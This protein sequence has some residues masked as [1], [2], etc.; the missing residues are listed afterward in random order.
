[1]KYIVYLT[2]NKKNGK[3]YIGVHGTANPNTFDGYLGCGAYSN[4]PSSYN[5]GK[6][7]FHKAIMKYGINNF[8]RTALREFDSLE[9]A[10]DLESLLVTEEFVKRTDTYNEVIGGGVP[11][12]LTKRIYQ[13]DLR[14]NLIKRW[15]SITDVTT[16]LSCNKNRIRMV[17]NDKRSFN[18]SY[19]SETE[20]I[21]INEFMLSIRDGVFQYTKDGIL[22]NTF[23]DASEAALKLDIDRKSIVNSVFNRTSCGGYYFLRSDEDI[24][25]LLSAKRNNIKMN[26]IKVY[27]YLLTGEFDMEYDS[28]E[29][30]C[31]DTPKSSHGNITRAIKGNKTCAGY[32]WS[33]ER[34]DVH[35]EYIPL[36][37]VKISQ[38]DLDHNLVKTWD[39]V[40]ECKKEFPCCQKVCR[41]ERKS[42]KGFIFEYTIS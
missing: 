37:P 9:D 32:K 30:A 29:D 11:P 4:K 41:K 1:M 23:N 27:R 12:M 34:H 10:L 17:I 28:I 14:G 16:Y 13:F 38:Y 33:Y 18:N 31:N 39:S 36:N 26:A 7:H 35:N 25:T 2:T 40:N 6:S 3:I 24:K 5:K 15:D 8:H 22:L 42:T 21:N 20:T 19:W